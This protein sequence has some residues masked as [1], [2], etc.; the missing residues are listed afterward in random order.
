[1]V[2]PGDELNSR[3]QKALSLRKG[4]SIPW[5]KEGVTEF[6]RQATGLSGEQM[7]ISFVS[8]REENYYNRLNQSGF[9]DKGKDLKLGVLV[10]E[11]LE[12]TESVRDKGKR[13]LHHDPSWPL[14]IIDDSSGQFE[15]RHLVMGIDDDTDL[16]ASLEGLDSR[17][18]RLTHD[19]FWQGPS[20]REQSG[21]AVNTDPTDLDA[22]ADSMY[23]GDAS[24]IKT[25]LDLIRERRQAILYG[26]PG[27]GKTLFAREMARALQ[28]GDESSTHL[29]QFHASYSYEDFVQGWRPTAS[30]G[31]E[32]VEG[33][34]LRAARDAQ[35]SDRPVVL[36]IDEI[37]R[38]NLSKVL[39]ELLFL[40]EYRD[41]EIT[42][43]YG[44][45]PF[46][47]PDN[48]YLIATMNTA[49]RSIAL[50]DAAL[51]RRFFFFGMFPDT[52][53]VKGVLRRFLNKHHPQHLWLADVLDRVNDMIGDRNCAIGPSHFMKHRLDE[54][55]IGRVWT[56]DILPHLEDFFFDAPD[57][58]RNFQLNEL[59]SAL[60]DE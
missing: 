57:R 59:R 33:P 26:P 24:P 12:F 23:F 19:S 43:Q 60:L 38:A 13:K 36:I 48:L 42:L 31:F 11:G 5:D 17:L 53:P 22:L 40:L 44:G 21:P 15:P 25:F 9:A 41:R 7:N 27:T 4:N 10:V 49:D 37:N 46:S 30:G 55:V 50:V 3:I 51:R 1:M 18:K 29:V 16:L 8:E 45:Q 54:E 58:L 20:S 52:A 47:I 35:V 34:L 28:A 39:G 56:Y 2:S 6:L 32:L 14:L